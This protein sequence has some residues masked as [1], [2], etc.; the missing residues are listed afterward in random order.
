M[1]S[2][3]VSG[4]RVSGIDVSSNNAQ[5]ARQTTNVAAEQRQLVQ[6]PSVWNVAARQC[7]HHTLMHAEYAVTMLIAC[8][9]TAASE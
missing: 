4:G 7:L 9:S 6:P 2:S 8:A 5:C 3:W 1:W